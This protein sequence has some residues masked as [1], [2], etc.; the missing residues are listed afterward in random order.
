MSVADGYILAADRG[1]KDIYL[2]HEG[3]VLLQTASAHNI[4]NAS[5]AA[6]GRF[7]VV[8]DEPYYK[9]PSQ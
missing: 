8:S 4:I 1:G 9:G 6:D 3:K 7:V 5:V 2:I